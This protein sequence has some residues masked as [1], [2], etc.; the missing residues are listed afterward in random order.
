M[1]KTIINNHGYTVKIKSVDMTTDG[2]FKDFAF[3]K[4]DTTIN[5]FEYQRLMKNKFFAS[6]IKD[7]KGA[8]SVK[9]DT[10]K[11]K[12]TEDVQINKKESPVSD[13]SHERELQTPPKG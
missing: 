10:L 1:T 12:K 7:S 5:E 2:T 6:S 8:L 13:G 4:G 11:D 9:K 3:P